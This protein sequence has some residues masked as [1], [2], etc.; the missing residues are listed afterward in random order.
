MEEEFKATR[1]SFTVEPNGEHLPLVHSTEV[2]SNP[3]YRSHRDHQLPLKL[4]AAYGLG[5]IFNDISAA[6]W[7]S[8]TLLFLQTV[9]GMEAALSGAMLLTGQLADGICTPIVGLMA[10]RFGSRKAWHITGSLLVLFSFPMV[11]AS[12]PGCSDTIPKSTSWLL[13]LYYA[14]LIIIFQCG[15]AVVQISHLAL[16]P[17]LTP[18][19]QGRSELTAIRYTASVCSSVTVYIITWSVFH[20]TKGSGL[21]KI[22][23]SDAFKFRDVVIVGVVI[24][25][26]TNCIF[27]FGLRKVNTRAIQSIIIDHEPPATSRILD[28]FRSPTLFQVALVYVTSRLFLTISLVYMPLYLN[29]TISEGTELIASVPLV[30]YLSSF[31]ASIGIKYL[32]NIYGSKMS[33]LCGVLISICGC[34]WIRYGMIEQYLVFC[35]Y[36]VAVF[37]GAGSSITMVSSLCIT[38][39]LIGPHTENGAFVYGIVT[40]ADKVLNGVAVMIIEDLKCATSGAC[41][42]YYRDIIAYVCGG[43]AIIGL[44]VLLTLTS[45][46]VGNRRRVGSDILGRSFSNSDSIQNEAQMFCALPNGIKR[47]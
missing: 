30:C 12:C 21:D 13:A 4:K 27:H 3:V 25:I 28:Y 23:P 17:D 18:T 35:I 24:G 31:I 41:P 2:S 22:G 14:S 34:I 19:Q 42:H 43:S 6:M 8:Y 15:W 26:M 32:N 44:I 38:A 11:F 9:L 37:L 39:D 36:G 47:S 5:H 1:L 20:A 40:F 16:I 46:N 7:F 33:Y 10:D 29:E 45:V